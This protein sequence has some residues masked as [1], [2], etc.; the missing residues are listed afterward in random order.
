MERQVLELP[1]LAAGAVVDLTWNA[2]AAASG[3]LG[4]PGESQLETD[5]RCPRI[6]RADAAGMTREL[7]QVKTNTR[8]LHREG[9]EAGAVPG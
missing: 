4:G 2:S 9:A 6:R 7:E 8:A 1:A 5:R 3:F